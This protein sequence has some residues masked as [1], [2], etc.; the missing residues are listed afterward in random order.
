MN[1]THFILNIISDLIWTALK[2]RPVHAISYTHEA[3][4]MITADR[5]VQ[6]TEMRVMWHWPSR[7]SSPL[8]RSAARAFRSVGPAHCGTPGRY[9]S[10]LHLSVCRYSSRTEPTT[11]VM[12]VRHSVRV[13]E[14]RCC[15]RASS[16][17]CGCPT[18]TARMKLPLLTVDLHEPNQS[19]QRLQNLSCNAHACVCAD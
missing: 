17:R 18:F 16:V 15:A 5:C 11:K 12:L 6:S 1:E 3:T 9:R 19:R 8:V 7:A 4:F 10:F 13:H 14:D 2:Q